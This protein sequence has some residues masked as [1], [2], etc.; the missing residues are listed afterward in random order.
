[1]GAGFGLQGLDA[2]RDK[3]T[4]AEALSHCAHPNDSHFSI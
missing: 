1:M 3:F 4:Q 2:A